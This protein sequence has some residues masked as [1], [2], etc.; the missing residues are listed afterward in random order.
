MKALAETTKEQSIVE[1]F[2]EMMDQIYYPGYTEEIIASD[3][4]KFDWE[5]KEFQGQFSIKNLLPS[6]KL[7]VPIIGTDSFFYGRNGSNQV[8]RSINPGFSDTAI[9]S[10]L[11]K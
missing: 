2:S 1:I 3:P 8:I 6:A 5:L 7:S 9:G 11:L 4:E 10:D